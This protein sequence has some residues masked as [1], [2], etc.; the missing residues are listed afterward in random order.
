MATYKVDIDTGSQLQTQAQYLNFCQKVSQAF[1]AIGL[2]KTGDTGQV[3]WFGGGIL[4]PTL[5][6]FNGYYEIRKFTDAIASYAP[7]FLRLE[8]WL[9]SA[10]GTNSVPQVRIFMGTGTD[11]AGNL[12]GIYNTL[13]TPSLYIGGYSNGTGT[14]TQYS[15]TCYFASNGGS[16]TV[17]MWPYIRSTGSNV[18]QGLVVS[19]ARSCDTSGNPTGAGVHVISWINFIAYGQQFFPCSPVRADGQG[20]NT[21]VTLINPSPI[22]PVPNPVCAVPFSALNSNL[23][24]GNSGNQLTVYPMFPFNGGYDDNFDGQAFCYSTYDASDYPFF[25]VLNVFGSNHTYLATGGMGSALTANT[26][27]GYGLLLR[28]E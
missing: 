24:S 3:D 17:I 19:M 23:G 10:N 1:T 21:D 8:Y 27:G 2:T 5:N 16:L 13:V 15:G 20:I 9:Q 14:L 4:L 26:I 22:T 25:T 6:T 18:V 12:T 28:F 11:G 7:V